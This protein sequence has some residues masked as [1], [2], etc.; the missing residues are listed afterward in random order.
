MAATKKKTAPKAKKSV[1]K[2][3]VEK[4]KKVTTFATFKVAKSTK[5]VAKKIAPAKKTTAKK[6]A[7][8]AAPET[9]KAVVPAKAQPRAIMPAPKIE[10]A[11]AEVKGTIRDIEFETGDL[12]LA[13]QDRQG[14]VVSAAGEAY[15]DWRSHDSQG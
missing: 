1:T 14:A 10:K 4:A 13:A 6:T 15:F 11:L 9:V 8:I 2:K 12:H 5:A 7:I 3:V